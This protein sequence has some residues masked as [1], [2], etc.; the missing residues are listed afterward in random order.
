[1]KNLSKTKQNLSIIF[2]ILVFFSA[3]ILEIFYFWIKYVNIDYFEKQNFRQTSAMFEEWLKNDPFFLQ[4]FLSENARPRM[5]NKQGPNFRFMNFV[6]LD[7]NSNIVIE[8]INEE[9]NED[10]DFK[11]F[12]CNKVHKTDDFYIKKLDI[13]EYTDYKNIIFIKRQTYSSIDLLSDLL[14]FIFVDILF[15]V[16]FYLIWLKFVDKNLKPVEEVLDDM[17]DFIHNANHELKTPISIISTNMQILKSTKIYEEDL[18]LN[19]INEIKRLDNLLSGLSELSNINDSNNIET[20]FVWQN[21]QVIIKEFDSLIKEKNIWITF[22]SISDF[23]IKAKKDY[24]YIMFSNLLKNAIKYN[25][26]WWKID[27]DISKNSLTISNTW[28]L[29]KP[30]ELDKIWDRFYKCDNSRNSEWFW[31]WLSLVKKICN[32]YSWKIEAKT[33]NNLNTFKIIF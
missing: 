5:H 30:E 19:S 16:V 31:I 3:L 2:A 33:E 28:E 15:W 7:K 22:K 24:F 23:E 6:I 4:W 29:I 21:T 12:T 18:I 1:M 17:N 14:L 11:N 8:N 26:T 32:I 9:I 10:F 25:I 20:F 27:I 13:W